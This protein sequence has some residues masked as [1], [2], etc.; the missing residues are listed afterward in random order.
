MNTNLLYPDCD[1]GIWSRSASEDNVTEQ[2]IEGKTI[3]KKI[4]T[5]LSTILTTILGII[6]NWINGCL[7][8]N[9]PGLLDVT[10]ERVEHLFDAFSLIQ[11]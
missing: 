6:P 1:F 5:F 3:G 9:G 4:K 10:G 2:P 7:Y 11:K 8:Q